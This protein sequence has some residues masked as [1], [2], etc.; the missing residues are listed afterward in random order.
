[1]HPVPVPRSSLW[2]IPLFLLA[3][4]VAAFAAPPVADLDPADVGGLR[5]DVA[6]RF[7]EGDGPVRIAPAASVSDPEGDA[8]GAMT[9]TLSP[10]ANGDLLTAETGGGPVVAQWD[11]ET[12]RL[13]GPASPE[14]FQSVLRRVAFDAPGR[15]P[16]PALR[17]IAVTVSDGNEVSE[18]VF[19]T[20]EI[21]TVN[22]RPELDL[23]PG[24]EGNDRLLPLPGEGSD[25]IFLAPDAALSDPDDAVLA[26]ASAVRVL[27]ADGDSLF[28][29]AAG[30]G[31]TLETTA[32]GLRLS[33]AAEVAVYRDILRTLRLTP[34]AGGPD[35]V[36][37]V[38]VS[39]GRRDSRVSLAVAAR[40]PGDPPEVDTAAFTE[41]GTP[42]PVAGVG[43]SLTDPSGDGFDALTIS[44]VNARPGDRLQA[45][46]AGTAIIADF[47]EGVLRLA[48]NDD[49]AAYTS[50]LR[51]A[52]FFNP[53][54]N[55][56]AVLRIVTFQARSGDRVTPTATTVLSVTPVND[57]PTLT[58][59]GP[60]LTPRD[61]P[62]LFSAV[63]GNAVVLRDVDAG[64]GVLEV[65][66]FAPRGTLSATAG[67][68]ADLT[69]SGTGDLRA[70][71]TAADIN[72]ALNGLR[73]DPEPGWNGV[74]SLTVTADDRGHT[75]VPGPAYDQKTVS[76]TV[77]VTTVPDPPEADAG[78][79][80][81]ADEGDRVDL[82]GTGS[83]AREGTLVSFVWSQISGPSAALSGADTATPFFDAPAVAAD[84]ALAF[85]LTVRDSGGGT[86]S[87][88][89]TVTVADTDPPPSGEP[90]LRAEEGR[91]AIL[92]AREIDAG[93]ASV[94]WEQISGPSAPLS[95]PSSFE[96]T[97]VAPAV[98]SSGDRLVFQATA[99]PAAGEPI[100]REVVVD[101]ADNGISGFP[102][103]A[104]TYRSGT[105]VAMG[106]RVDG[107]RLVRLD[108][109]DPAAIDDRRGRPLAFPFGLT[110][111]EIRVAGPGRRAE[112][113]FHLPAP[114]DPGDR[115][116][117]H[118]P[119]VGWYEF[120]GD[121]SEDRRRV[122]IE[123]G[124][125]SR[126]DAD[127]VAN[128]IIVDPSGLA[129]PSG[130]P[131]APGMDNEADGDGG[132]CFVEA[133]GLGG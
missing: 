27:G 121:F 25:A 43:A 130:L 38:T 114:A 12:L 37:A 116:F 79:D 61:V 57:A 11:G 132:G 6:V 4:A 10:A 101:V 26:G 128:G 125:G 67:N 89:V 60:Q 66:L 62:L 110:A 84:A 124:D 112:I 75:G 85:R 111:F 41:N 82:D 88:E 45:D 40:D 107:G 105:G 133:M 7:L 49:A 39:D 42:E 36:I 24:A 73:F 22:D 58:V 115:W 35:R 34:A 21:W 100:R 72:A 117:K 55:P 96:P 16:D 131:P 23:D 28:A 92:R 94:R 56:S 91:T 71:G 70:T 81:R 48:G 50:A 47:V 69:G 9:L 126:G 17:E 99:F 76:I 32:D 118:D 44:I 78:P 123:I 2:W 53:S 19:A 104:L 77:A 95:D 3:T 97:F 106:I 122:T 18:P 65:R 64:S 83:F 59:P 102:D 93:V 1:M 109:A 14:E 120:G 51:S 20:V 103:D 13:L 54:D 33:G 108:G 29:D 119:A 113:A 30:T 15:N 8:P 127:G 63:E 5:P 68:G 90:D 129:T 87:D 86:D 46:T 31:V 98:G 52:T 80:R 74:V